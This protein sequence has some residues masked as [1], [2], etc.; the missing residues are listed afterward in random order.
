MDKGEQY[1][2]INILCYLNSKLQITEREKKGI[3]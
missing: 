1:V 3:E 2:K